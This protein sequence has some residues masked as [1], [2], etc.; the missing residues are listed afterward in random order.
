MRALGRGK[1]GILAHALVGTIVGST[2][3]FWLGGAMLLRAAKTGLSEYAQELTH[4][5]DE[6]S[7]EID[8]VFK[9]V[10]A[11]RLPICSDEEIAALQ[12]LTFHSHE[13]KDIGRTRERKLSSFHRSGSGMLVRGSPI[14]VLQRPPKD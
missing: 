5:A 3:G 7:D 8:V 2:L 14:A 11:S 6:L 9:A 1:L 10:N 13:L 12:A 4:Q